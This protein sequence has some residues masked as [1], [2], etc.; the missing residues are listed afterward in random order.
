[1]RRCSGWEGPD[2]RGLAGQ[3][4][5]WGAGEGVSPVTGRAGMAMLSWR[6]R[7]EVLGG[8]R[9]EVGKKVEASIARA[10]RAMPGWGR[11]SRRS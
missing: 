4:R 5:C 7:A 2:C 3:G 6:L 8:R 10:T 9:G 1:M 11:V